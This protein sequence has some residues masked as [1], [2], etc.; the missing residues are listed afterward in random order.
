MF[1]DNSWIKEAER[2]TL[3]IAQLTDDFGEIDAEASIQPPLDQA[4]FQQ[5]ADKVDVHIPKELQ[6]FWL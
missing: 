4:T 1:D 5:I 3:S 2:F 6:N